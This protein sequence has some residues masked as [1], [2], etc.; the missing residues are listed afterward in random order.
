MKRKQTKKDISQKEKSEKDNY[1]AGKSE[2]E[3]ILE[4]ENQKMRNPKRDKLE[5][6]TKKKR[7]N[8]I[9]INLKSRIMERSE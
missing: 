8:L 3:T 4:M 1:V 5:M 6:S 2:R 7:A 9:R